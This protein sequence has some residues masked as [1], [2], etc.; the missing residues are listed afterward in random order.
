MTP[1]LTWDFPDVLNTSFTT[2]LISVNPKNLIE[3]TKDDASSCLNSSVIPLE[4]RL[5]IS[6][7]LVVECIIKTELPFEKFNL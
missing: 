7:L 5:E 1:L 2:V 3:P 4:S 6:F